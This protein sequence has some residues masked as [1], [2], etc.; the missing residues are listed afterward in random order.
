L[1]RNGTVTMDAALPYASNQNNL[2]LR[3]ADLGG[4]AAKP[5]SSGPAQGNK[6]SML[7]MLE[8]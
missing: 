5:A 7:D 3:L 1:I 6:D 4:P 2:I 8:R